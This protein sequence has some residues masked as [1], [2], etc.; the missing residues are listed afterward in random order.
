[1]TLINGDCLVEG[2][3]LPKQSVDLILTDLPYGTTTCN[4]DC[5]LPFDR[6]WKVVKWVLKPD[7]AFITTASQPFS[8]ALVM[9]NPS[10]F[11]H[12]WI[13]QKKCPSNFAQAKHAPMKEHESVLV[14]G[15]NRVSYYPIKEPRQ[16]SGESRIKYSFSEK[17]KNR[18][19]VFVGAMQGGFNPTSPSLRF[20]SSVRLINNRAK[21]QR[22]LH[23]TQK[24]VS[25]FEY[26]CLTYSQP[27]EVV[28]DPCM[29][30][31][32]TGIAC[33]NTGRDFV[34]I[35]SEQS[36]YVIAEKRLN[37]TPTEKETDA[38]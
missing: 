12:E 21:G 27:G 6:L 15:K 31:G 16:G 4:W 32:T 28:L 9:S 7:G 10:W 3:K 5:R 23:P 13:Y 36:Y 2:L 26:L 8:S 14:F 22:G 34:G 24:P 35:E 19:G 38:D 30:S 37:P 20:P 18:T 11:R 1:M 33:L 29:G 25:L 17:T